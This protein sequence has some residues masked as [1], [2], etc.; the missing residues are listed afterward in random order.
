MFAVYLACVPLVTFWTMWRGVWTDRPELTRC[1]AVVLAHAFVVQVWWQIEDATWHGYPA[2][3]MA[4]SL[5]VVLRV[6]CMVPASRGNAVLAGSV[7]FGILASL[8]Y[9]VHILIFGGSPHSDWNYGLAQFVMGWANLFILLGWTHECALRS[10]VNRL[11]GA[12]AGL[13]QP[14]RFGGVA[15]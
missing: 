8:I 1:G 5:A 13:V 12:I 14:A 15:R 7:L 9:S 6:I 11:F 10:A 2:A 3:F 4:L